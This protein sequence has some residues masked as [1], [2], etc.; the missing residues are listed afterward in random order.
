[1]FLKVFYEFIKNHGE[2]YKLKLFFIT[3]F[4]FLMGLFEF[5]GLA[6]IFPFMMILAGDKTFL[7]I[8]V[9]NNLFNSTNLSVKSLAGILCFAIIFIYIL[10]D[11]L[12]ILCT[13][14]QN[15]VMASLQYSIYEKS[16][17]ELIYCP[18]IKLSNLSFG[19][20]SSLLGNCL[21]ASVWGFV[22]K[23]TIIISSSIIA[24]C[25]LGFLFYKFAIPALCTGVFLSVFVYLEQLFFKKRA[26]EYGAKL[27]DISRELS[28]LFEYTFKGLKE[29][30]VSKNRDFFVQNIADNFYSAN[31]YSKLLA[32]NG[33]YPVYVTE[34][35]IIIAFGILTGLIFCFENGKPE[36]MVSSLAIVAAVVLRLVPILNKIQGSMFSINQSRSS[37][38]WF[39]ETSAKVKEWTR[40]E[41]DYE[42]IPFNDSIKLQNIN[43]TYENNTRNFSLDNINLEIKKGEFIG[44]VG[45]SGSGKTTVMD[46]LSGINM[47]NS[48]K[49]L[50]DDLEITENNIRGWHKKIAIL[51]QDFFLMP[52][53][54]LD[55][56]TFGDKKEEID[57]ERVNWALKKAEIFDMIKDINKKPELSYGQKHRLALARAFYQ[58]ADVLFLDEATSSLDLETEDKVSKSISKLKGE[59]T[60]IAIAH[61]LSTLKECDALIF[62]KEGKIIDKGTFRELKEKYPDFENM[63][64]LST[65]VIP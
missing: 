53:S 61:R 15:N 1:M 16:L 46:I 49:F 21:A 43:F 59:K 7:S 30:K 52:L 2:G 8:P 6:L 23:V 5:F 3:A 11:I 31:N 50:V 26:K 65:L 35:G 40:L 9:I 4:S 54:V 14:Y 41:P 45:A 37:I 33:A 27:I 22:H 47:P 57:I 42:A 32:S 36:Y 58:K 17:R 48:G 24:L 38:H 29:I 63:L 64:E 56:V 18:Y 60:I 55:N 13:R 39:L 34:I 44:I 28:S 62:M 12:M 19:H 10:K 20:K 25:I 51:P